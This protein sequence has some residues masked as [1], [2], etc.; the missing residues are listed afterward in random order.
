MTTLHLLCGKIASGKSTLAK[1]LAA[2]HTAVVLSED[3][4]LAQLYPA[5]ILSIADYLRCAQRIRG[6]LGPLVINLLQS[7]VNVVL[8][9]PANTLANREWLLG[10]AQAAE[11][12]H[13]LHYLELDDATCR[14]RL[15]ARNA[16]GEHDFAATDAEF[17]LITRHFCVPSEDEGLVIEVHRP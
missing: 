17:D 1:T 9:F 5:Q 6:V 14:A 15:H 13:C 10:L 2:E 16:R 4:W 11:V 7:G 12:P 8:D 3:Q